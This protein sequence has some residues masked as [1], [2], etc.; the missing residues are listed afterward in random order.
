MSIGTQVYHGLLVVVCLFMKGN[1]MGPIKIHNVGN[2]AHA[3][4]ILMLITSVRV[5]IQLTLVGQFLKG[6]RM[7]SIKIHNGG[8]YA[9]AQDS[10]AYNFCYE[11]K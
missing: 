8:N 6:N 4:K 10:D 9:H 11:F 3:R 2:Y 1:S 5:K 7:G